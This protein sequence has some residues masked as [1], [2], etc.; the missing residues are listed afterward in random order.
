VKTTL[1]T[2]RQIIREE[3]ERINET[4][5]RKTRDGNKVE[6]ASEEYIDEV[7]KD[8]EE[9][10]SMRDRRGLR[11]RERYVLSQAVR[12]LRNS[13]SRAR[14]TRNREKAKAE[15]EKAPETL[16]SEE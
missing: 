12:H 3:S 4:R 1:E 7:E 14:R 13:L 5:L 6:F 11:E 8:L 10:S 15:Q 9:L 16:K 2:L